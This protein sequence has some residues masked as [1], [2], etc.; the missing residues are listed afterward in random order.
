MGDERVLVVEDSPEMRAIVRRVLS[1]A[2]YHVDLVSTLTEAREL[3]PGQYDAVLI[4]ANLG[5]ERGT[6][7]IEELRAQD[8]AAVGRCL[9]ITGG[10]RAGLPDGVA[11]LAKPF[12]LADLLTAVRA[13][14]RPT[15]GRER[16][17]PGASITS[18]GGVKPK[19]AP[20]PRLA[21]SGAGSSGA[22]S[23][24]ADS[25]GAD[26]SGGLAGAGPD[27]MPRS[28]GGP[29]GWRLLGVIR[30]LRAK[31]RAGLADCLH[32]GPI[33]DLAA[34]TLELQLL[35]RSARDAE[36]PEIDTVLG[37][38]DVAARSLRAI[39]AGAEPAPGPAPPL[40][41]ALRQQA[42]WLSASLVVDTG[43]ECAGLSAAEATA[44]VDVAELML[45]A[46]TPAG[47]PAHAHAEVLAGDAEITIRLAVVPSPAEGFTDGPADGFEDGF[48]PG[49]ADGFAPGPADGHVPR[50]AGG[51]VPRQA[52]GL[53]DPRAEGPASG[54]RAGRGPAG[55]ARAA[56]RAALDG[57][58]V[59]LA[60]RIGAEF[61]PERWRCWTAMPRA[62]PHGQGSGIVP[63]ARPAA[64]PDHA[65]PDQVLPRPPGLNA[66][67][68]P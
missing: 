52:D 36:A 66:A 50:P 17:G 59:V 60:A 41:E 48:A 7:L 6:D 20:L 9:V 56:V 67:I 49:P 62:V 39:M 24:G 46:M 29:P 11:S 54:D 64:S 37:Q 45:F 68:C 10:S 43:P 28:S 65:F 22:G 35:R 38:L 44:A 18:Q 63:A 47:P 5:G 14:H 33:Q 12:Q 53:A 57:L 55:G 16:R 61:G 13:L 1:T 19:A 21:S 32:D 27:P 25:A 8:E 3:D 58:A 15:A 31:E 42:A 51:L 40:A 34:A 23:S 2:G 30:Q 26:S 4:D